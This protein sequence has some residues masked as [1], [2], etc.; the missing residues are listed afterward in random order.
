MVL[1][2]P[3]VP[4]HPL[5][6]CLYHINPF[7][8]LPDLSY[9][10]A[11]FP[12]ATKEDEIFLLLKLPLLDLE[13]SYLGIK[14]QQ[15][16]AGQSHSREQRPKSLRSLSY[17]TVIIAMRHHSLLL[18]SLPFLSLLVFSAVRSEALPGG[19][20]P[21]KDLKERRVVEIANYAVTEYDKRSGAN[22][23]LVKV[24]KGET[25]VVAGTNYRLVLKAKDGSTV[26]NYEA[27]VW[28][29]PWV[30]FR[31]LTSFEPLHS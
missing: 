20:T 6:S 27:I 12:W 11:T 9:Q 17:P 30:H 5:M 26:L 16:S 22:L 4:T 21:I 18:V 8:S 23:T 19:W 24:V 31:N 3:C 2:S 14:Y 10:T 28:E 13:I 15:P 29:K 7:L 25:Q 1:Y